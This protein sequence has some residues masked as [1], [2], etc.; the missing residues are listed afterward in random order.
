MRTTLPWLLLATGCLSLP[1]QATPQCA[2]TSDCSGSEVCEEGV[3]WGDPPP[4]TFSAVIGPPSDRVDLVS[5][6]MPALL[7]PSDGYLGELKLEAPGV[8]NGFLTAQCLPPNDCTRAATSLGATITLT[9]PSTLPNGAPFRAVV[10]SRG[11]G[12]D[13]SPSFQL[14]LPRSHSAAEAY[15][16][17]IVPDGRDDMPT[18]NNL[19]AAQVVPPFRLTGVMVGTDA[20]K[21]P[22]LELQ[23]ADLKGVDGQLSQG[24]FGLASYR[25]VALGRWEAGADPVEVST[26]DY[27]GSDGKFHLTLAS[28]LVGTFEIVARPYAG[29][30]PT[31]HAGNLDATAPPASVS[32]TQPPTTGGDQLV[33]IHVSAQDGSGKT[34]NVS[35]ARVTVEATAQI[36]QIGRYASLTA[37]DTTDQNGHVK[38]HLLDGALFS[39][40]YTMR[41]VPPVSSTFGAVF[42]HAVTLGAMEVSLPQ[43]VAIRGIIA[44]STGQPLTGVSI[45][46]RP[47]LSFTWNL[48]GPAQEFL[49]EI[50]A[51]ITTTPATGAFVVWVDPTVA[52]VFGHYDLAFEPSETG[53]VPQWSTTVDM[54]RDNSTTLD[55]ST[56][57]IPQPAF[58]HGNLVDPNG[59]PVQGGEIKLYST[60]TTAG[61]CTTL[62]HPPANCPIPAPLVARGVREQ[63]RRDAPGR[64]SSLTGRWGPTKVPWNQGLRDRVSR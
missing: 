64:S 45:T 55:L 35:G 22:T 30:G 27:T 46:A 47:A 19:T 8:F 60:A 11:N 36:T 7:L 39:S 26:V 3:C 28:G 50:P 40:A 24:S 62:A 52:G 23:T 51:A 16:V 9:R 5:R 54:P 42:A 59:N 33:D 49:G 34:I 43:R 29:L 6:E 1:D 61:F 41:I 21:H 53:L 32:M 17:L 31:L 2:S 13:Q 37:S 56:L 38:L 15:T 58:L 44:D 25:V 20:T 57:R 18:G 4:G 12:T 10:T 48:D 63:R 14:S